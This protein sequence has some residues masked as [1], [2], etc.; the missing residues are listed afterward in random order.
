MIKGKYF[1]NLK[2]I[3]TGTKRP[4]FVLCNILRVVSYSFQGTVAGIKNFL[5]QHLQW[6][7]VAHSQLPLT[8]LAMA[9]NIADVK[10]PEPNVSRVS[11]LQQNTQ[12]LTA[13]MGAGSAL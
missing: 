9:T 3:L 1:R 11:V 13:T 4:H 8:V 10:Y 5:F 6:F 7:L 12:A 2:L